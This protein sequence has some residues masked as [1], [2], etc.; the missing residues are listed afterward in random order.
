LGN[1]WGDVGER[2]GSDGE[3]EGMRGWSKKKLYR[4]KKDTGVEGDKPGRGKGCGGFCTG[5]GSGV[6][7]LHRQVHLCRHGFVLGR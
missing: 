1:A 5:A 3:G 2:E 6:F 4:G 7:L